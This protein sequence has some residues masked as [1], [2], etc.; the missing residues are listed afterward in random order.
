MDISL[1]KDLL[2][3][4]TIVD[5]A[6]NSQVYCQNLYAAMCNNRFFYNNEEWTCS[7]RYSGGIISDILNSGDYIDWYCSG[8]ASDVIAGYVS[9]GCV[10]DEIKLDLLKMGWTI[11]PYE[12][13]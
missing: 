4:V 10:T 1:E 6:K 8:L 2:T 11:R 7:W 5:K 3:N 13:D 12:G 9:E